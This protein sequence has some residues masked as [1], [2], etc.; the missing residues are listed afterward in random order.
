MRPPTKKSTQEKCRKAFGEKLKLRDGPACWSCQFKKM[1]IIN[2]SSQTCHIFSRGHLKTLYDFDNAYWGCSECNLTLY[3]K[4]AEFTSR[5][6]DGWKERIGP[7]R[8]WILYESYHTTVPGANMAYF[9]AEL[10]RIN[11]S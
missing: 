11:G 8:W 2:R 3:G 10:E 9:E 6:K 1:P 5:V 7:L 4:D